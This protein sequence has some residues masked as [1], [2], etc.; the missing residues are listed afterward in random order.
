LGEQ[1][2]HHTPGSHSL[3]VCEAVQYCR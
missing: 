3:I 2:T 1:W